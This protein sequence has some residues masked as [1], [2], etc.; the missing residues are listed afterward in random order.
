MVRCADCGFLCVRNHAD[1]LVEVPDDIRHNWDAQPHHNF[2][3]GHNTTP[4]CFAR[5]LPENE[6]QLLQA[7]TK[8]SQKVF[9]H[10]PKLP[11][12]IHSFDGRHANR[13]GRALLTPGVKPAFLE[14]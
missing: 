10:G 12:S 7:G 11:S 9:I 4:I 1:E 14:Q 3:R 8:D 2:W 5:A 13:V 6:R